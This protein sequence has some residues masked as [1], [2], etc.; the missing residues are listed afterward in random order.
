MMALGQVVAAILVFALVGLFAGASVMGVTWLVGNSR[1]VVTLGDGTVVLLVAAALAPLF[2]GNFMATVLFP[3]IRSRFA[4]TVQSA[5]MLT[6][7]YALMEVPTDEALRM[8]GLA[9]V[10]GAWHVALIGPWASLWLI[11]RYKV[12]RQ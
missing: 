8:L 4:A 5:A 11:N 6:L 10:A 1:L 9:S 3:G 2:V 7:F 12:P